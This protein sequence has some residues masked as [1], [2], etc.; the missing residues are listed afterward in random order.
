MAMIEASGRLGFK[1]VHLVE[2]WEVE[3]FFYYHYLYMLVLALPAI[4]F[5][6]SLV[7]LVS[8]L[9]LHLLVI[10]YYSSIETNV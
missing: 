8:H 10:T 1:P 5:P 4:V 3:R 2:A 9:F 7:G 6:H